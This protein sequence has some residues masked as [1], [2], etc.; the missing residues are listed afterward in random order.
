MARVISL[1]QALA[2]SRRGV[3]LKQ[4][5]ERNGWPL[6]YVYRDV[7]TLERAGFPI[8]HADGRYWLPRGWIEVSSGAVAPD[9]LLALY[10]ARQLAGAL[11]GTAV[12]RALDRLWAKLSTTDGQGQLLPSSAGPVVVRASA[13]IDYARHRTTILVLEQAVAARRAVRAWYRRPGEEVATERVIEPGQLHFDP[14]LEALYVI[15]WCRLREAVRVFAV[16]RFVAAELLDEPIPLR[17]A[18]RSAAALRT[19]FRLWRSDRVEEV[20]LRF[21]RAVADE[22]AERRWHAS[23]KV[24]RLDGGGL[25]LTLEV[26]EPE[27]LVRWLVGFGPD[28]HVLAPA[29]LA[30][31]VRARHRLALVQAEERT[32]G[33]ARPADS[34]T[35]SDNARLQAGRAGTRPARR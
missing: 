27:E 6:R 26:A 22:I 11:R 9:E 10:T 5:A 7:Q 19:A 25:V 29:S 8:A 21:S 23:Q 28:V 14:A 24:E 35:R 16:H 4:Y 30:D 18:T 20:R 33:V 17:P 31:A 15:A 1:A 3:V 32:R 13:G 34:L 12:G 2:A